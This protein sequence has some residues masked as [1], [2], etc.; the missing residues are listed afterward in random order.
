MDLKYPFLKEII[1][2]GSWVSARVVDAD[3]ASERNKQPRWE[4]IPLAR[5][6]S[7]DRKDASVLSNPSADD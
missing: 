5:M 6:N 2:N 4:G 1:V 3:E 7:G